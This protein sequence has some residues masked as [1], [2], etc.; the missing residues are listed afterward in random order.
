LTGL[1]TRKAAARFVVDR[2]SGIGE[3]GRS[4][5]HAAI[6][7]HC[8]LPELLLLAVFSHRFL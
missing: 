2:C 3:E 6:I 1:N 8:V 4:P 7:L 5:L